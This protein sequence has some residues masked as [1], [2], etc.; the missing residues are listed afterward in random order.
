MEQREADGALKVR[1]SLDPDVGGRPAASPLRPLLGEQGLDPDP[2]GGLERLERRL[3]PGR[4]LGIGGVR[5]QT[6]QPN[7]R[8]CDP[9]RALG[10]GHADAA[11]C[12][13]MSS[14]RRRGDGRRRASTSGPRAV[15][16]ERWLSTTS[17]AVP[18]RASDA[19]AR[20]RAS[21]RGVSSSLRRV[22]SCRSST[23]RRT[24]LP[25]AGRRSSA[26]AGQAPCRRRRPRRSPRQRPRA[27][28][29]AR[30]GTRPDDAIAQRQQR[31]ARR[32]ACRVDTLDLYE[33]RSRVVARRRWRFRAPA[34]S[35]SPVRSPPRGSRRAGGAGDSSSCAG[36]WP[37]ARGCRRAWRWPPRSS[38]P[39]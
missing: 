22:P 30:A 7:A 11:A 37:S 35:G 3:G 29:I 2:L 33:P 16:G 4:L 36:D 24:T 20:T 23:R 10:R 21:P 19:N 18:G 34:L 5:D 31:R 12:L 32:L 38:G 13:R 25:R 17:T 39:C 9:C 6:L 15:G 8:A 1:V 14:G 26:G 28:A 27:G